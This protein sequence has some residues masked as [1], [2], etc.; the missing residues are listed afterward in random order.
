MGS[1]PINE[2]L[3]YRNFGKKAILSI[4][5][6]LLI[7]EKI[8]IM[9]PETYVHVLTLEELFNLQIEGSNMMFTI[10]KYRQKYPPLPDESKQ[11][12]IT[13]NAKLDQ[14]KSFLFWENVFNFS[15]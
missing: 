4:M 7:T 8:Q 13:R 5:I 14:S 1:N 12:Y 2:P 3:K 11:D 9:R 10:T 15:L 6:F